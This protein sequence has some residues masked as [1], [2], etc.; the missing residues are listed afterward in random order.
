MSVIPGEYTATRR[1]DRSVADAYW[2]FKPAKISSFL[3]SLR[4]AW[5]ARIPPHAPA[6]PPGGQDGR[7]GR[8]G[9]HGDHG[10]ESRH[11]AG[12]RRDVAAVD[13]RRYA[14]VDAE[15]DQPRAGQCGHIAEDDERERPRDLAA[16]G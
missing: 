15:A 14:G 13:Q 9:L 12:Q 4:N 2:A 1:M 8:D 16:V 5:T 10:E 11:E 7:A 6:E 3:R